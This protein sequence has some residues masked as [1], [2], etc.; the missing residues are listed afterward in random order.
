[1]VWIRCWLWFGE[2]KVEMTMDIN[3]K[4]IEANTPR[5]VTQPSPAVSRAEPDDDV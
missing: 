3:N 4:T 2:R 1:M 5:S